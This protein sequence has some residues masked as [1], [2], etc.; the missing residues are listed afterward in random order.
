MTRDQFFAAL[1]K[2]VPGIWNKPGAIKEGN[3]LFDAM[4]RA[5]PDAPTQPEAAKTPGSIGPDGI[6]LIKA[7]EGCHRPIGGGK[8]IAYPDPGPTGLP[9]TIGWGTT[10]HEGKA[11]KPGTVWTQAEC[12][13]ALERDLVKY[14]TEVAK[15]LGPALP[16]TS[17]RQFD[18]M[19]S[20]HYN[21]GAIAR[22]TL[23]A[24]HRAGD[25]KGAAAEFDRWNRAGG[26]VMKGLVRRRAAERKLYEAGT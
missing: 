23:T 25:F 21:T 20:F 24:K 15:A 6:A 7:F 12:D 19:V 17:Q 5:T 14:A 9:V 1:R 16:R 13:A 18:A 11:I 26:R 4:A 3:E 2:A 8:F 10:R 22:A